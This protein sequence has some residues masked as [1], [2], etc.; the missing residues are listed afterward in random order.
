MV[1]MSRL[2]ITANR[3]DMA[4]AWPAMPW[5]APRSLA[6]GVNRL[7]GMNSDAI[8]MATHMAIEPTALHVWRGDIACSDCGDLEWLVI[9]F[10]VILG[11]LN[12]VLLVA[13]LSWRPVSRS[14]PVLLLALVFLA[15]RDVSSF[16][17]T[18]HGQ[19]HHYLSWGG[20]VPV[21][22]A[23]R[24]S[25]HVLWI[26]VHHCAL[27]KGWPCDAASAITEDLSAR[28]SVALNR[29]LV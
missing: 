23:R 6:I 4:I 14:V 15:P 24:T 12:S 5:V 22:G 29:C 10:L 18:G 27:L 3:P 7:T 21:P 13:G 1:G 25:Q 17:V 26:E 20:T 9:W 2:V 16:D 11:S 8:S 28:A 19:V